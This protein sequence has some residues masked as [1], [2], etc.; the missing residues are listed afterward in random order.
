MTKHSIKK[1]GSQFNVITTFSKKEMEDELNAAISQLSNA[2][3]QVKQFE[4][5]IE[6]EKAQI[7]IIKLQMNHLKWFIETAAKNFQ[8]K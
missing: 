2:E 5:N 3:V 7:E 8:K 6:A 1:K 4:D